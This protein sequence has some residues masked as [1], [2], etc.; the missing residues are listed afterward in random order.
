MG[1]VVAIL[2]VTGVV[3]WARKLL[4]RVLQSSGGDGAATPSRGTSRPAIQA[5]PLSRKRR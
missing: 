1:L 4:V 2:S 3:I 5:M